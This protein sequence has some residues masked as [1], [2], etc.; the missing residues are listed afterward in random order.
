MSKHRN[1]LLYPVSL[2][3][4]TITDFRNY[5]YDKKILSSTKYPIPI[6]CVGNI[7]RDGTGKTPHVEYIINILQKQFKVAV[8]CKGYKRASSGFRVVT[9]LSTVGEA[10]DET[11]QIARKFT[12][13]LVTVDKNRKH[14]IK[15]IIK[16][17]PET[18]VI[19]LVDAF[20][21]RQITFG[22]SV[23]LSDYGRLMIHDSIL[24]YGNL[25]EDVTN[26]NRADII[27][28]TKSPE[29]ICPLQQRFIT[30]DICKTTN[31]NLFFTTIKYRIPKLLLK[32]TNLL[33]PPNF[34][35]RTGVVLVTGIENPLPF[36]EFID[37]IAGIV[38]HL[39]YPN[40]YKYK[41]IDMVKIEKSFQQL[42]SPVKYIITTEKDSEKLKVL[43]NNNPLKN[44]VYYFPIGI[45][46]L[47]DTKNGFDK[48]ITNYVKKNIQNKLVL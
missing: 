24:P 4:K 27:I 2:I 16:N 48:L 17:Y 30:E 10:N 6:I 25:R 45:E 29:E 7:T 33:P 14:G 13:V 40:H 23:L 15:K 11:L 18:E 3:Y 32:T 36:K 21:Q 28:I 46:F 38:V 20:Q 9:A 35:N 41:K 43:M 34:S 12:A 39:Q 31:Q 8:L 37:T 1:F 44:S 5:L 42:H 26:I 19:L 22:L 47:H